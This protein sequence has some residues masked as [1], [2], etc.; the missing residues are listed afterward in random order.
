MASKKKWKPSG[1]QLL[2]LMAANTPQGA[3]SSAYA[4]P[5]IDS[6]RKRGLI[7]LER[8]AALTPLAMSRGV[9]VPVWYVTEAGQAALQ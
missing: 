4:R 3:M 1:K 6:L 2:L 5:T 9:T 7:V 8:R